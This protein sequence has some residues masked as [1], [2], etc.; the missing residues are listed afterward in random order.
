M[1]AN[2]R[3]CTFSKISDPGIE[4]YAAIREG[5]WKS[6]RHYHAHDENYMRPNDAN[7]EV[8][9]FLA[10]RVRKTMFMKNVIYGSH[11]SLRHCH[12]DDETKKL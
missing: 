7:L 4:C 10:M 3:N 2:L 12:A 5:R 11:N 8:D 9:E 6:Q 1:S